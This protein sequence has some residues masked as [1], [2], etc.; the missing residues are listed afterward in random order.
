MPGNKP[1]NYDVIQDQRPINEWEKA[2]S[3][4]DVNDQKIINLITPIEDNDAANKAYVDN[5]AL[6]L[7]WRMPVKLLDT[8]DTTRP[9]GNPITIDGT[10][11]FPGDRVLFTLLS[12]FENNNRVWK[13]QGTGTNITGWQLE[14]DGK[15]GDGSPS[16]GD[17]L[18]VKEGVTYAD[19]GWMFNA[20]DWIQFTSSGVL[21]PGAGLAQSGNTLFVGNGDGI[22][23]GTDNIQLDLA[24]VSGLI[25][26]GSSPNAQLKINVDNSSIEI[27]GSNLL[28]VKVDGINETHWKPL[29]AVDNNSQIIGNVLDPANPQDV[30]TKAY[31]DAGG[32]GS[33]TREVDG[34]DSWLR[35][36]TIADRVG[37]GLAT[38]PSQMLH[39]V[40][41]A[42]INGELD[43]DTHKI[44]N[45]VDPINL[46]DVATKN[47]VDGVIAGGHWTQGTGEVHPSTL[48][49]DIFPNGISNLG[50]TSN[51]F[52]S[53]WLTG[54]IKTA[55]DIE[56]DT[57][58]IGII[59]KSRTS[60]IRYRIYTDDSG[61]LHTETVT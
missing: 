31:V 20:V 57:N 44:V 21:Y 4:L 60:N 49:D 3:S 43:I 33:W 2:T 7:S 9:T 35:P 29:N 18:L 25:M 54:G 37:I 23:I 34:G 12:A 8:L 24:S 17:A 5:I 19:Q 39:V 36:A 52:A 42:I 26:V 58:D 51:R 53:L 46:Q 11:V 40:G 27:N 32:V 59:V 16:D 55:A 47:Y 10:P 30:A 50:D 28:Q 45:V 22:L 41:D 1:T 13:A 38:L 15:S 6:G 14:A 61:V 56:F 48:N